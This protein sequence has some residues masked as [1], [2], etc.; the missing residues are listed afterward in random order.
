ALTAA[1]AALLR[2]AQRDLAGEGFDAA[3][4][5][6]TWTLQNAARERASAAGPLADVAATLLAGVAGASL[7]RLDARF[8]LGGVTLPARA[9]RAAPTAQGHRESPFGAGGALPVYTHAAL[10][11]HAVAGPCVVDGGTF[12]WLV[13]SGWQLAVDA[14][15]D[16]VATR[17]APT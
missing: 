3:A 9:A 6:Y 13:G 8:P 15:G 7:L 14:R 2:Q 1:G 12:T 10:T 16:A 17:G 4:A 11:G 5:T